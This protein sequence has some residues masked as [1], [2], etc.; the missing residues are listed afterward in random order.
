MAG[1][2]T[3]LR[4]ATA[5]EKPSFDAVDLVAVRDEFPGAFPRRDVLLHVRE[6]GNPAGQK[7]GTCGSTSLRE[8]RTHSFAIKK[9]PRAQNEI[10]RLAIEIGGE[11]D[12]RQSRANR[13]PALRL[14]QI[15]SPENRDQHG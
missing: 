2:E 10:V 7:N 9:Q 11:R 5:A 8:E 12:L 13:N 14:I 1:N 4:F 15:I 3:V 6:I